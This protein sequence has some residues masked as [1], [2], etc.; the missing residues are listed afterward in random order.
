MI[1][2]AIILGLQSVGAILMSCMLVAPAVAAR[3]WT[4]R[5][6]IMVVIASFFGGLSGFVGT[7]ISSSFSKLPTG[8]MISIAMSLIVFFSLLFA[9]KGFIAKKIKD[10][11][12]KG[13]LDEDKILFSLYTLHKNHN[14]PEHYYEISLINPFAIGKSLQKDTEKTMDKLIA[15]GYVKRDGNCFSITEKGLLY[16]EEKE[17]I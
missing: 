16:A 10:K 17:V 5:L 8:P 15:K 7:L 14:M 9:P 6:G 3:Q 11:K 12:N 2:V 4:D 1:V 13:E